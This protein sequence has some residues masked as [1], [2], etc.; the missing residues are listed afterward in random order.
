M[1]NGHCIDRLSAYVNHELSNDERHLIAEHILVCP[2]CRAVH[3]EIRTGSAFASK[4]L[5]IDAPEHVWIEIERT[6]D[7]REET[8]SVFSL[9]MLPRIAFIAASICV[10]F[11]AVYFVAYRNAGIGSD[12]AK[13]GDEQTPSAT[14]VISGPAPIPVEN[15]LVEPK[16]AVP[17]P[18]EEQSPQ[19]LTPDEINS[20]ARP[21]PAIR[22][23]RPR[24]RP[25]TETTNGIWKVETIEGRPQIAES[26]ERG[27]IR[28]GEYLETDQNSSARVIVADIGSVE[29]APNSRMKLVES[30]NT[31]HR[32]ALERGRLHARIFAPPRLFI[33]DTPSAAAVD[34][35]CEYVLEVNENGDSVLRVTGGYVALENDGV[36]S[37]VPA[38]ASAVTKK[39][40]GIGLPVADNANESFK[41]AVAEFD[42]GPNRDNALEWILREARVVDSLT[43]WHL[44]ARVDEAQRGAVFEALASRIKPPSKVTKDGIVRLDRKMLERWWAEVENAWFDQPETR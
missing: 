4:L 27:N 36:E 6:L 2:D 41:K 32:L 11:A 37:I 42:F 25:A 26:F 35:G 23:P 19:T 3:D 8:T 21:A 34:L 29:V 43:I 33:V 12:V 18:S 16:P 40:K 24:Q 31:E 13:S 38:L 15:Q 1:E 30:K 5:P 28:V 14:P 17:V 39:G 7:S 9:A 10:L 20:G 22:E 44:F